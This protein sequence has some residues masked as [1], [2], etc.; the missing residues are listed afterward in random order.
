MLEVLLDNVV[1]HIDHEVLLLVG[2][3][4]SGEPQDRVTAHVLPDAK[5][6][7]KS[8]PAYPMAI[9]GAVGVLM[10]KEITIC[11]GLIKVEDPKKKGEMVSK[12]TAGDNLRSI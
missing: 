10:S 3:E 6:S 9:S 2:G 12:T 5:S 4:V 11:G 1:H 7:C 8:A